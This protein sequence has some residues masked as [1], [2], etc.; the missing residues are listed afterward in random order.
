MNNTSNSFNVCPRCGTANS[1][2]ARY[3]YQCGGQL[4]AP[5]EPVACPNCGAVNSG[6]ANFCRV[7]G[8]TLRTERG[9]AAANSQNSKAISAKDAKYNRKGGRAVAIVALV[10]LL[11]FAYLIVAPASMRPDFLASVGVATF[12]GNVIYGFEYG[13]TVASAI[14]DGSFEYNVANV[15]LAAVLVMFALC[16]VVHLVTSIVRI[17]TNKK[18]IK[19]NYFYLFMSILTTLVVGLMILSRFVEFLSAFSL[20]ETSEITWATYL[21]PGYFW[22]FFLYSFLAKAKKNK[23]K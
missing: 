11:A 17:F 16:A 13:Y 15:A 6:T 1:L 9:V 12:S 4:K 3:C 8:A 18:Q 14:V 23:K 7:C 22:F 21:V 5:E 20:G 19:P 2:S 10:F